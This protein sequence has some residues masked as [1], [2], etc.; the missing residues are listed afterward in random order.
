MITAKLAIN[1]DFNAMFCYVLRH[2]KAILSPNR[3]DTD[4]PKHKFNNGVAGILGDMVIKTEQYHR[5]GFMLFLVMVD[6][7]EAWDLDGVVL[8][9]GLRGSGE[10]PIQWS[11]R[12]GDSTTI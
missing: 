3:T 2:I 10:E 12:D 4:F 5:E 7:N 1:Y 8:S 6:V 11:V 9:S